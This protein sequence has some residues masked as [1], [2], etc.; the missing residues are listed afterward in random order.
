MSLSFSVVC[1]RNTLNPEQQLAVIREIIEIARE[2]GA[3]AKFRSSGNAR[4][5]ATYNYVIGLS[6]ITERGIYHKTMDF[7]N[8]A[9]RFG[10]NGAPQ[11]TDEALAD[12]VNQARIIADPN[13]YK[14]V[15]DENPMTDAEHSKALNS[16][17]AAIGKLMQQ[18]DDEIILPQVTPD[19]GMTRKHR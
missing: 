3:H 4:V 19:T 5:I 12:L 14:P 9:S 6:S 15:S 2:M 17:Q 1:A 7:Q 16:L 8:V 13:N 11:I 18:D 10:E